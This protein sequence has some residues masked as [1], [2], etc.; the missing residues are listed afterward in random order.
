MTTEPNT[1]GWGR[2]TQT[3]P[4]RIRLRKN[5][6]PLPITP[7]IVGDPTGLSV[8]QRVRYQIDQSRLIVYTGSPTLPLPV[9]QGGTGAT[10]IDP[11]LPAISWSAPASYYTN[12]IFACHRWGPMCQ[13]VLALS[14]GTTV[15][16]GWKGSLTLAT[17]PIG[18]RPTSIGASGVNIIDVNGAVF[19]LN[20]AGALNLRYTP[21]AIT[22]TT[23]TTISTIYLLA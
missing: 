18:F 1:W 2:V 23:A 19:A 15:T 12:G 17:L 13:L 9:S 5:D 4:A 3:N 7:M 10:S 14:Y 16:L 8:G 20:T 6:P 22:P 11:T 21:Y